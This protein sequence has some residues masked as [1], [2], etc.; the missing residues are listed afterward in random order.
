MR[1]WAYLAAKLCAVAAIVYLSAS[2]LESVYLYSEPFLYGR[3]SPFA[4]DLT[5]TFA[6]L[7]LFLLCTGL[8]Y[9]AI[10]D[11]RYRCRTCLRRL[12]MPVKTG[13]WSHILFGSSK[14]EYICPYGHGTLKVFELQITGPH[15]PDWKEHEDIWKEL[16]SP[17]GTKK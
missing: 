5:Y 6:M 13:S 4:H 7:G 1:Y 8:M 10:L 11:T 15:P 12:R 2:W 9:A 16:F 3:H 14:T 17:E